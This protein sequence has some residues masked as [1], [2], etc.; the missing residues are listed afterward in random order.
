MLPM[1]PSTKKLLA[2]ALQLPE[3]TRAELAAALVESLDEPADSPAEVEASWSATIQRR[4]REVESGVVKPIPW[5]E[6]R[7]IIFGDGP[8]NR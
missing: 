1:S 3:E 2:E 4:I 8:S 5:E 6:A 7:K